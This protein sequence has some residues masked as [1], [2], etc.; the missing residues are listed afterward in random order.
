MQPPRARAARRYRR[1]NQRTSSIRRSSRRYMSPRTVSTNWRRACRSVA[2]SRACRPLL[3]HAMS[4]GP[5]RRQRHPTGAEHRN[6]SPPHALLPS[7]GNLLRRQKHLRRAMRPQR[8]RGR[9]VPRRRDLRKMGREIPPSICRRGCHIV[10]RRRRS[11]APSP[12]RSAY[13][14]RGCRP[15]ARPPDP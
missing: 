9:S 8:C 14:R 12:C 13:C 6:R 7:A 2:T 5:W 10:T 3:Y 1:A 4:V 11:S 15:I